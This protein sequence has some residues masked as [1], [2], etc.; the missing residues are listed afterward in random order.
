MKT[1]PRL[2]GAFVDDSSRPGETMP[3][4][5]ALA[6]ARAVGTRQRTLELSFEGL[7]TPSSS[8]EAVIQLLDDLRPNYRSARVQRSGRTFVV[9]TPRA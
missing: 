5:G 4:E 1:Y 7:D 2:P 8:A 9:L 6:L 3:A